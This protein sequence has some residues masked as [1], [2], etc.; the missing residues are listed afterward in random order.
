[1][2]R[3]DFFGFALV[4]L[5]ALCFAIFEFLITF[6]LNRISID[7]YVLSRLVF[8]ILIIF[9]VNRVDFHYLAGSVLRNPVVVLRGFSWPLTVAC[10]GISFAYSN[11]QTAA[12]AFFVL[13]PIWAILI[14]F[15]FYAKLP[16]NVS[17]LSVGI[18]LLIAG[19]LLFSYGDVG[20]ISRYDGPPAVVVYILGLLG[21]MM[22]AASNAFS[23]Y[24]TDKNG[25]YGI[26]APY[27]HLATYVIGILAIPPIV[28]LLWAI[29]AS[30]LFFQ[31]YPEPGSQGKIIFGLDSAHIS[32]AEVLFFLG[33]IGLIGYFA[34]NILSLAI[35]I[36]SEAK[37][38]VVTSLELLSIPIVTFLEFFLVRPAPSM[39]GMSATG[40]LLILAGA[41]WVTLF[42]NR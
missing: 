12:Y 14:N 38:G 22:F 8:A 41:F 16:E 13:H 2:G 33:I 25:A 34:N 37:R 35:T 7:V 39:S 5:A 3:G 28:V 18:V 1:V 17:L 6:T 29:D 10:L 31:F 27:M 32:G 24:I 15:T 36:T 26:A 21:G 30:Y 4:V 9:I 42:S 19:V 23:G 40:I 20:D 11:S